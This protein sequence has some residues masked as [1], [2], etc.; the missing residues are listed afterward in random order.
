MHISI[1]D[2]LQLVKQHFGPAE[3]QPST[4]APCDAPLGHQTTGRSLSRLAGRLSHC[5]PAYQS[6]ESPPGHVHLDS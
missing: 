6:C 1:S 5:Q 2:Q 3:P 4:S